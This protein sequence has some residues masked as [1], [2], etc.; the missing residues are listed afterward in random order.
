MLRPR[1]GQSS[2]T[3]GAR[4]DRQRWQSYLPRSLDSAIMGWLLSIMLRKEPSKN[5]VVLWPVNALA[6]G[7]LLH[8]DLP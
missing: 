1:L 4:A 5:K 6:H 8:F 3:Y 2:R 7:S